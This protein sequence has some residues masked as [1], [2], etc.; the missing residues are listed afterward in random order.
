LSDLA[1]ELESRNHTVLLDSQCSTLFTG[2]ASR[3]LMPAGGEERRRVR[4]S[5][6]RLTPL[7]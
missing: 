7:R 6:P 2:M 3:G 5:G 4:I 1:G